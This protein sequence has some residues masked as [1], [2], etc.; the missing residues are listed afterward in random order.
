MQIFYQIQIHCLDY[1]QGNTTDQ[2]IALFPDT[3][4][5]PPLS[6]HS[7]NSIVQTS[8]LQSRVFSQYT[9]HSHRLGSVFFSMLSEL[10]YI[11][12]NQ[13]NNWWSDILEKGPLEY[14]VFIVFIGKIKFYAYIYHFDQS[15]IKKQ[16]WVNVTAI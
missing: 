8:P 10:R 13:L 15:F 9:L 16:R 6:W 7:F 5:S 1:G 4:T 3:L 14:G 12:I 11:R 2:V